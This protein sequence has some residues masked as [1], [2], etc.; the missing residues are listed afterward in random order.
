MIPTRDVLTM[1]LFREILPVMN[2]TK[3]I[4]TTLIG[5]AVLSIAG[6]AGRAG[7]PAMTLGKPDRAMHPDTIPRDKDAGLY[8]LDSSGE[9]IDDPSPSIEDKSG[10]FVLYGGQQNTGGYAVVPEALH[11]EGDTASLRATFRTP[12]PDSMVTQALTYPALLV[13]FQAT[14]GSYTV[15]ADWNHPDATRNEIELTI[16]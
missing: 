11:A 13:P 5:L 9:F 2:L 16:N 4:S 1:Q 3:A 10:T 15:R 7:E 6:C 12:P 8:L 14:P